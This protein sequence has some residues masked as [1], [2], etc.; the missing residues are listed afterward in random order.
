MTPPAPARPSPHLRAIRARAAPP[1]A[2]PALPQLHL[3]RCAPIADDL[4]G[5]A[6]DGVSRR[7]NSEPLAFQDRA[8]RVRRG[9]HREG[10]VGTTPPGELF[11]GSAGHR[12]GIARRH[13][14][15]PAGRRRRARAPRP[16]PGPGVGARVR[17]ARGTTGRGPGPPRPRSQSRA[18]PGRVA[19][20]PDGQRAPDAGGAVQHQGL[21]P[22]E[23]P[24]PEQDSGEVGDQGGQGQGRDRLHRPGGEDQAEC[25]LRGL[26]RLPRRAVHRPPGV[27]EPRPAA[28]QRLR[29]Q[30]GRLPDHL[31]RH[32]GR[33][34]HVDLQAQGRGQLR[35]RGDPH[36]HPEPRR[37]P[38][39]RRHQRLQP[40]RGLVLHAGLRAPQHVHLRH[41]RDLQLRAL[42][43]QLHR[44]VP[45][46]RHLR[47][48]HAGRLPHHRRA[49]GEQHQQRDHL[50]QPGPV[51]LAV[52][53]GARSRPRR[54]GAGPEAVGGLLAQGQRP[55][56]RE[57]RRHGRAH[58]GGHGPEDVLERRGRDGLL[59]RRPPVRQRQHGGEQR[60]ADVPQRGDDAA[61]PS[62][63]VQPGLRHPRPGD[64]QDAQRHLLRRR[65]P[66]L[67]PRRHQ[68]RRRLDPGRGHGHRHAALRPELCLGR[69]Q[70]LELQRQR[71]DRDRDLCRPPRRR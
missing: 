34:L 40:A 69:G 46:D 50:S 36:R 2:P 48:Q 53:G 8:P 3:R 7:S 32:R 4:S 38:Q 23:Q 42:G 61:H 25:G 35:Q 20:D 33:P 28:H 47:E 14:S 21:R 58:L 15:A 51:V 67:H 24:A 62:V 55:H 19:G 29:Q 13:G 5:K 52:R 31:G 6:P 49:D 44:P 56:P 66:R 9:V 59:P 63:V 64:H 43:R 70:R 18:D 17:P 27:R 65:Q 1:P 41:H 26:G 10:T 45:L 57:R 12:D 16:P 39:L 54:L 22:G 11:V 37:H 68:R 71:S 30:R 60:R